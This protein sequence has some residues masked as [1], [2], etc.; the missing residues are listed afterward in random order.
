MLGVRGQLWTSYADLIRASEIVKAG[1]DVG[2]LP[3]DLAMQ[4][5]N[6][7]DDGDCRRSVEACFKVR[8]DVRRHSMQKP[9]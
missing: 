5:E 2:K 8:K 1:S 4:S 9:R 3:G 6:C 7:T